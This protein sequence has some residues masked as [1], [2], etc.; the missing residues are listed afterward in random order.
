MLV[1]RAESLDG[2]LLKSVRLHR[3]R[4]FLL[5]TCALA[6]LLLVAVGIGGLVATNVARRV[7]EIG[8]RSALG[9]TRARRSGW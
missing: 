1:R 6:G 9:A 3:F 8:I 5:T 4:T 7:R 2:A